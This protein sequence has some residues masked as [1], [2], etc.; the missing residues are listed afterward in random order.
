[1]GIVPEPTS[2]KLLPHPAGWDGR[3]FG[4]LLGKTPALTTQEALYILQTTCL[5]KDHPRVKDGNPKIALI[6]KDFLF[7]LGGGGGKGG[8]VG[9]P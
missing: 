3:A 5:L 6:R 2:H 8:W 7:C 4:I 1:M 9:G